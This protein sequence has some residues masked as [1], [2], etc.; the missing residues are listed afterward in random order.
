MKKL[1]FNSFGLLGGSFDPPHYGHLKISKIIRKMMKKIKK[2]V[3]K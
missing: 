2:K 3:K 1:Q